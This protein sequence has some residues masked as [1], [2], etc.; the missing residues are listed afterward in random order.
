MKVKQDSPGVYIPPP[1]LY[2]L[3]FIA[4]SFLQKKCY[5]NDSVFHITLIRLTGILFFIAALVFLAASLR[6]FF[7]TRNTVVL[8]KSATSLQTNGIYGVSR[9]PMYVGLLFIYLGLTCF[10]GS[11]W[12][13]ILVPLLVFI[14][15]TY[16]IKK[17]E[18]YLIR[19]FGD[20]FLGYKKRVR[21]WL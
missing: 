8:I 4:A 17:E 20:Q 2:V 21:R 19:A 15:Q 7:K 18:Q 10:I 14:L 12:H 16:I 6:T 9:N 11:W 1:L 5:I 3:I 13:L